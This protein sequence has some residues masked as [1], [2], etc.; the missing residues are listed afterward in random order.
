M[1]NLP[2]LYLGLCL[3]LV[4]IQVQAMDDKKT[5]DSEKQVALSGNQAIDITGL[6]DDLPANAFAS[7]EKGVVPSPQKNIPLG[8]LDDLPPDF[9]TLPS[10]T[11]L[12]KSPIKR[13]KSPTK[14][15]K[16]E[17]PSPTKSSPSKLGGL[18]EDEMYKLMAAGA[19]DSPQKTT[20]GAIALSP[21]SPAANLTVGFP[22]PEK[23]FA[24]ILEKKLARGTDVLATFSQVPYWLLL[25][26][27]PDKSIFIVDYDGYIKDRTR[28]VHNQAL[29]KL[30]EKVPNLFIAYIKDPNG[31]PMALH[32]KIISFLNKSGLP[33][34]YT[35]S[36]N[37]TQQA[38]FKNLEMSLYLKGAE[39]EQARKAHEAFVKRILPYC[40]MYREIMDSPLKMDFSKVMDLSG[41]PK[42]PISH[43]A[44]NLRIFYSD[45]ENG[46]EFI[47]YFLQKMATHVSTY[48]IS[49]SYLDAVIENKNKC[50]IIVNKDCYKNPVIQEALALIASQNRRAAVFTGKAGDL[51]NKFA[52][53][54][55]HAVLT[56]GGNFTPTGITGSLND[57]MYIVDPVIHKRCEEEFKKQ[58]VHSETKMVKPNGK[59]AE[60]RP[61]DSNNNNNN[62]NNDGGNTSAKRSLMNAFNAGNPF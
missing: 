12:G 39:A 1:K 14:P 42:V 25:D 36:N 59:L 32:N 10:P 50:D 29:R 11:K 5:P 24:D 33:R 46:K 3:G 55:A 26:A 58:L 9:F 56:G 61:L 60:K 23:C 49:D 30:Q 44:N 62:N 57:F 2:L 20:T 28:S 37:L 27:V 43:L 19:F 6:L 34:V 38:V 31:R 17:I 51:H 47:A 18:T 54:G 15:G 4:T 8:L 52:I 48:S 16:Q 22:S 53:D 45:Q 40:K 35:G 13:I 21:I 7:P 41:L